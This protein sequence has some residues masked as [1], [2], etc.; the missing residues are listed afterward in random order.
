[1]LKSKQLNQN[2]IIHFLTP[3]LIILVVAVGGTYFLVSSHA[4]A[5]DNGYK[6]TEKAIYKAPGGSRLRIV[7]L[8]KQQLKY[9]EKPVNKVK[10]FDWAGDTPRAAGPWC[11]VFATWVWHAAGVDLHGRPYPMQPGVAQVR[12]TAAQDGRLHRNSASNPYRPS[13][14]DAVLYGPTGGGSNSHVGI[15]EKVSGNTMYVIEGNAGL[16]GQASKYVIRR[17]INLKRQFTQ[18][19]IASGKIPYGVIYGYVTP[20]GH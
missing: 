3:L 2:G 10:F 12:D 7:T 19:Y 9:A 11:S 16:D 6:R 14:G 4:N 13:P 18:K 20:P 15:V 8:A 5:G 1:M 17:K